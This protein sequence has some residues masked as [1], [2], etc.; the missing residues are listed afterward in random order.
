MRSPAR[1][2][3]EVRGVEQRMSMNLQSQD[4]G[5][6]KD[7]S[8]S[9]WNSVRFDVK[10]QRKLELGTVDAGERRQGKIH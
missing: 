1:G 2:G 10:R 6:R 8:F 7:G 9:R 5:V 4:W 3:W